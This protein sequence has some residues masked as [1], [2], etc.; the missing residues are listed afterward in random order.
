MKTL[1][2]LLQ[3]RGGVYVEYVYDRIKWLLQYITSSLSGKTFQIEGAT[4]SYFLHPYNQTWKNERAVEIPVIWEAVNANAGKRILEIGN[5]LSHYF[6]VSHMVVDKDERS[7]CPHILNTDFLDYTPDTA[8]DLI[9]SISTVEHI[10]WNERPEC[11]NKAVEAVN[12]MRHLLARGGQAIITI[13][14]GYNPA[15]DEAI[16]D[17]RIGF[18]KTVCLMR[19]SAE[20]EWSVSTLAGALK[21]RYGKP[22]PGANGIIIGYLSP[23][24]CI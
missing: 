9:I 16:K 17:N 7:S 3:G 24:P 12:R 18:S 1:K 11:C 22:F 19:L 2:R 6:P 20:N 4:Y 21:C 8:F 23:V 14:V 10:G 13:P 15:L 5:V